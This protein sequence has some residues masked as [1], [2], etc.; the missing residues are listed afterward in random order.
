MYEHGRGDGTVSCRLE[1]WEAVGAGITRCAGEQLDRALGELGDP[2]RDPDAAIHEARKSCKRLR[3]LL[4]LARNGLGDKVWRRENAAL[5]DA[6]R[7]LSALR[8]AGV[9]LKSYDELCARFADEVGRQRVVRVRRA[10]AAGR[11]DLGDGGLEASAAAFCA[12]LASVRERIPSWRPVSDF[13]VLSI[14]LRHTYQRARMAM[15]TAYATQSGERFHDW[16]KRVK[17]HRYHLELL[18]GLWPRQIG[19]RRKEVKALGEMLGD[20]HDLWVL[21]ARLAAFADDGGRIMVRSAEHRR[22]ELRSAMRPLGQ[23]VF[24]ERPRA[25]ARRFEAYWQ[26]A[27]SEA[28]GDDALKVA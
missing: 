15:R 2:E 8:D 16:R 1:P 21:Q 5:R 27:R 13:E 18:A 9:M 19:S 23:R 26:A 17:D 11:A 28:A 6:A 20:E 22:A 10:V 14:G 3:A 7:R 12:D 24:A 25:L 4:R